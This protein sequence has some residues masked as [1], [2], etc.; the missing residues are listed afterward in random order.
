MRRFAFNVL[1][2]HLLHLA[3]GNA[4]TSIILVSD[5]SKKRKPD[6]RT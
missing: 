3:G 4:L 2:Y 5:Y 6:A 1:T